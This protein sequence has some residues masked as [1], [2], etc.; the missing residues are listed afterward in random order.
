MNQKKNATPGRPVHLDR[1]L[2]EAANRA[3]FFTVRAFLGSVPFR[4]PE[5]N[6]AVIDALREQST[7]SRCRVLPDQAQTNHPASQAR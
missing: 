1:S 7:A 6:D 3:Y 2:Y 5:L 4:S